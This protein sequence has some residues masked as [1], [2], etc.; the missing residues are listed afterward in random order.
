[1]AVLFVPGVSAIQTLALS[2]RGYAGPTL[3]LDSV[4]LPPLPPVTTYETTF[5][6][7]GEV[8]PEE[9]Q[10]S[11]TKPSVS[12]TAAV[13]PGTDITISC[14]VTSAS[15]EEQDIRV[16]CI[17]YEGS[18]LPGHGAKLA[19]KLSAVTRIM[20]GETKAFDFTHRTV[21]G[22]IDRRDV[23]VGVYID[24]QL[25]KASEW[26]DVYYVGRPPEETIDFELTRPSVT[27]TEIAPGT[28]ITIRCPIKSLCADPQTIMA[29]VTIYEGSIWPG[30][31]AVITAYDTI[32]FQ[33]SPRESY[34]ADIRHTA[35]AGT[36]DRRDVEVQIYIGGQPVKQSEWDDVY[37]VITPEKEFTLSISISP[38]VG[39]TISKF[40]DKVRYPSGEY[41]TLTA[42]P[43]PGYEFD[44]WSG[45]ASGYG[46]MATVIMDRNKSVVAN[47][48]AAVPPPTQ[49]VSFTI[50]GDGFPFLT[51]YWKL[52]HYD[53][54]GNVWQDYILHN[55]GDIIAVRDVQSAGRLSCH[56][57]SAVTG[58]WTEQ[59]Y[60]V[61]FAAIDGEDYKYDIA[62][63]IV[64]YR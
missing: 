11:L 4:T 44:H 26:D 2:P 3:P 33:I 28:D 41:V 15:T 49:R 1:M 17:I 30:H 8:P 58:E 12:P 53:L 50:K 48:K 56:C 20:P 24:A 14:P 16:K 38:Y 5:T 47:F 51:N 59:F 61:E 42:H 9:V 34:N 40:P 32:D 46:T 13:E 55:P 18:A 25:V 63:G 22:T 52:Y 19:E 54:E 6:V 45:D 36:I 64:Y 27:P 23:E 10:F 57:C 35:V 31:G 37:Y 7:L 43:S 29:R 60:S 21:V 39:G 62:G